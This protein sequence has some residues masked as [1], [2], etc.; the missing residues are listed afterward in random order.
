[1]ITGI[2]VSRGVA[3]GPAAVVARP[4]GPD[5]A[6]PPTTP[7]T[8][9]AASSR[10]REA[11][12]DV[13]EGLRRRQDRAP[14]EAKPT[15]EAGAMMAGDPGLAGTIDDALRTGA[16]VT[17]AV[18]DAVGQYADLL[19]S[20][21]GYMADRVADLLDVRDRVIAR[22]RGLPEPGLPVL[23]VPSIVVARDLASAETALLNPALCLGL[24]TVEGGP[25]SH[26]AVL[27]SGLGIPAVVQ[28]AGLVVENGTF[29]AIDGS[30]GQVVVDPTPAKR[31]E[32]RTRANQRAAVLASSDAPGATRDGHRVALLANIGTLTDAR[33]AAADAVEGVGLFRTEFLFLDRVDAP[34]VEE[35][36]AA[37]AAVLRA[38]GARHVAIRTLDA[39]ADKPLAFADLGPEPNPALGRRGLRLG[40]A[41]EDILVT[42]LAALA[43]AYRETSADL[44]VMAPMVAT[45]AEAAW[46]AERVRAAGIPKVGVMIE[47]PAAALRARQILAEVDFASLGTNDLQQHTMAADRLAGELGELLD[48]WQ[49]AVL[50]VIAAACRGAAEAGRPIGVCGE[51]AGDPGLA[52]VLVGLGASSLSMAVQKVRAVRTVLAAHTLD[53]CRELA[54]L[55]RSAVGPQDAKAAVLAAA[56]PVLRDVI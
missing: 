29:V 22:L 49:P 56:R 15:L 46:F 26:A 42:Q 34:T 1:M 27:A 8:L 38:F 43:A 16:G 35:Q 20:L 7:A 9:S 32:F 19:L 39:G 13:A 18:H 4:V 23:T 45:A 12:R 28:A 5:P 11:L 40:M 25:T 21:G 48:P 51:S 44:S 37:Y 54:G 41:R 10:V 33:V 55:A 47:V 24:V 6:E 3:V 30:T 2:G 31:A 50:D 53:Q 14:D 52:L 36:T 17:R